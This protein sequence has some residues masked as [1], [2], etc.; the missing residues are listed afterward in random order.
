M[1]ASHARTTR[2]ASANAAHANRHSSASSNAAGPDMATPTLVPEFISVLAL[3]CRAF[4]IERA[5]AAAIG[6]E[7]SPVLLP[8][9][10]MPR[11]NTQDIGEMATVVI[12]TTATAP[13][14]S[15]I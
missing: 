3:S 15:A 2:P 5:T 1:T 7:A 11:A 4:P 9:T 6:G 12:P 8:A 13:E 14:A 10:T